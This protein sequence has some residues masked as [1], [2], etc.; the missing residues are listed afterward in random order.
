MTLQSLGAPSARTAAQAL[1]L[2][3]AAPPPAQMP[4]VGLLPGKL[5]LNPT[6]AP[7]VPAGS[8]RP[9]APGEYV[10]N[11]DGSWSSEISV[12]VTDPKLNNG[13]PTILPSL[14]VVNGQP[15]RVDEDTATA[16]AIQSGL[17]WQ[18]YPDLNAAEKAANAREELWQRIDQANPA[19]ASSVPALWSTQ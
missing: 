12:T 13:Q 1:G 11:P 10:Q 3:G 8:P 2:T 6:L 7:K 18:S 16:Y 17:P 4:G 9:F 5:F 15:V 19:S 14:W